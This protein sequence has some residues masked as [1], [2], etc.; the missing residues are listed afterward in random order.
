[1]DLKVVDMNGMLLSRLI[2]V[3]MFFV[4]CLCFSCQ[5]QSSTGSGSGP[6]STFGIDVQMSPDVVKYGETI[7]ERLREDLGDTAPFRINNEE[8]L[9]FSPGRPGQQERKFSLEDYYFAGFSVAETVARIE[10]EMDIRTAE[11]RQHIPSMRKVIPPPPVA[12]P[13][14]P[15]GLSTPPPADPVRAVQAETSF[16]PGLSSL[17]PAPSPGSG[18]LL[19]IKGLR[20]DKS[21]QYQLY[22]IIRNLTPHQLGSSICMLH[23]LDSN[24]VD[25]DQRQIMISKLPASKYLKKKIPVPGLDPAR[26]RKARVEWISTMSE[27]GEDLSASLPVSVRLPPRKNQ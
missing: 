3:M 16:N 17:S 19:D 1:M 21:S 5:K 15:A 11:D 12:Q 24:G 27:A 10:T 23:F 18:I 8:V 9:I 14:I 7:G 25:F 4:L 2:L 22:L 26:I 6:V 13:P 20:K